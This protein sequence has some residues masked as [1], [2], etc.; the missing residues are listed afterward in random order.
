MIK[1][2]IWDLSGVVGN[3]EEPLYLEQF[4]KTHEVHFHELEKVY[5][6][7]LYKAERGEIPLR[8]VWEKTLHHFNIKRHHKDIAHEIMGLKT[9]DYDV[10]DYIQDL[11]SKCKVAYLT[12]YAEEY[13]EIHQ[14]MID[15]SEYFDFGIVSYQIKARKP[16]SK[17]FL[18]IMH[19]FKVTPQETLFIDDSEKNIAAA[20]QLG[21]SAIQFQSLEQLKEE[22]GKILE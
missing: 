2:I 3:M 19:Q 11:R 6:S 21:I 4:A 7:H 12:N 16:D 14:K 13:W 10:L 15:L 18:A 8:E 5:Y 20:K 22:I 9:F 1:L 17:G